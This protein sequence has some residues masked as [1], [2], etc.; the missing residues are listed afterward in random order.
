M[1]FYFFLAFVFFT[2]SNAFS[3][4][5]DENKKYIQKFDKCDFAFVHKVDMTFAPRYFGQL[6]EDQKRAQGVFGEEIYCLGYFHIYKGTSR[7]KEGC[8]LMKVNHRNGIPKSFFPNEGDVYK[9]N[10]KCSPSV[11]KGL[12]SQRRTHPLDVAKILTNMKRAGSASESL[13]SISEEFNR[14]ITVQ[15][16]LVEVMSALPV[17]LHDSSKGLLSNIFKSETYTDILQSK[18]T[19]EQLKY[20][21]PKGK[22][23]GSYREFVKNKK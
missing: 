8:F 6:N 3:L 22:G 10:A 16:M 11:F 19:S 12:L 18:V 23:F 21:G 1:K 2:V 20:W 4:S 14:E 13:K 7:E 9:E 17:P 5:E 15:E